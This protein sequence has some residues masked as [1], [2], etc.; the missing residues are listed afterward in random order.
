MI[1]QAIAAIV[2]IKNITLFQSYTVI[3]RAHKEAFLGKLLKT[4]TEEEERGVTL[5]VEPLL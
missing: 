4:E 5:L 2:L 3:D 1:F